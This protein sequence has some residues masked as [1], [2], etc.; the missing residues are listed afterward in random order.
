[1][2]MGPT[3]WVTPPSSRRSW[4]NHDREP[5]W[6]Q[7]SSIAAVLASIS[8]TPRCTR[9][10]QTCLC[11]W[12]RRSCHRQRVHRQPFSPCLCLADQRDPLVS[13]ACGR[14]VERRPRAGLGRAARVWAALS[15]E[16]VRKCWAALAGRPAQCSLFVFEKFSFFIISQI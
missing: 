7:P 15:R 9:E 3:T 10:R 8:G 12:S 5:P 16:W 4:P 6:P 2:L 13:R 14:E 11:P 1:M